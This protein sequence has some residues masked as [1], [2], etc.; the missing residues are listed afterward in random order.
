LREIADIRKVFEFT[1]VFVEIF[2]FFSSGNQIETPLLNKNKETNNWKKIDQ[3]FHRSK[4]DQTVWMTTTQVGFP[5]TRDE[6]EVI[7]SKDTQ[8]GRL[9]A[10]YLHPVI[11]TF[12]VYVQPEL[13]S[14]G[15]SPSPLEEEVIDLRTNGPKVRH[16]I[17]GSPYRSPTIVNTCT[18]GTHSDWV[19]FKYKKSPYDGKNTYRDHPLFHMR[20]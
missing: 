15:Q 3:S 14:T 12:I 2:K 18:L 5:F 16:R 9:T 8:M 11:S 19:G 6:E 1:P 10:R 20:N 13:T 7:N 17:L 4:F